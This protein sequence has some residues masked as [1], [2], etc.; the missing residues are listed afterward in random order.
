MTEADYEAVDRILASQNITY[1]GRNIRD[2]LAAA[3]YVVVRTPWKPDM[4][5]WV[6]VDEISW[7]R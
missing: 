2:E 6:V 4:S 3:G 5:K 7:P 1:S